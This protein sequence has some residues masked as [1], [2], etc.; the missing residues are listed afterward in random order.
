MHC[1]LSFIAVHEKMLF[2]PER[3]YKKYSRYLEDEECNLLMIDSSYSDLLD[4]LNVCANNVVRYSSSHFE[5]W[6]QECSDTGRKV[7]DY[8]QGQQTEFEKI[9]QTETEKTP[10]LRRLKHEVGNLAKQPFSS[11]DLDPTSLKV[12]K[13][14]HENKNVPKLWFLEPYDVTNPEAIRLCTLENSE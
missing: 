8:C 1:D 11:V 14:C 6:T 7:E 10:K 9:L 5:L 4:D 2:D 3:D 13:D 12:I